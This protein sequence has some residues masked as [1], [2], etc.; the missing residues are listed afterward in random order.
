VVA[1]GSGLPSNLGRVVYLAPEGSLVEPGD[2]L[3]RFDPTPFRGDLEQLAAEQEDVQSQL[4]RAR[5][6]LE[7]RRAELDA[8]LDDA[9]RQLA[10]ALLDHRRLVEVEIPARRL[11]REE[12]IAAARLELGSLE[13]LRDM[14]VELQERGF[15]SRE[16]LDEARNSFAAARQLLDSRVAQLGLQE[17]V[18]FAGEIAEADLRVEQMYNLIARL[19]Q[20]YPRQLQVAEGAVSRHATRIRQLEG[21]AQNARDYIAAST[22]VAPVSGIVTYPPI[23][24]G[25][26]YRKVQIGDTVWQRQTF[27]TLPDLNS[28]VAHA[29]VREVDVGGIVAGQRV[30]ITASAYPELVLSGQVLSVGT[31]LDAADD[32]SRRFEVRISLETGDARLR[33]GMTGRGRIH[34]HHYDQVLLVPIDAVHYLDNRPVA[35]VETAGRWQPQDLMLGGTDGVRVAVARG[36]ATGQSVALIAPPDSLR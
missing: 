9:R 28:L 16:E 24:F 15:A 22:I 12:E 17:S 10:V 3:V 25:E 13:K 30:A 7:I 2:E 8:G 34:T 26:D 29:S 35:Y 20:D 11:E 18:E 14:T 19:E 6:E 31:V 32:R 27:L 33:P 4:D 23:S 5:T 36:L 1:I 21:M